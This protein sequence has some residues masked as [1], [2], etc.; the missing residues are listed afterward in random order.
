ME[1]VQEHINED[2]QEDIA[3]LYD[4]AKIA[5]EEMCV[6]K[7]E[8]S[9]IKTDMVWVKDF[10]KSQDSRLWWILATMVIG[11]LIQIALSLE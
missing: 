5:N 10:L 6:I 1:K 11:I 3:K 8:I 4:H 9:E 2:V 7:E